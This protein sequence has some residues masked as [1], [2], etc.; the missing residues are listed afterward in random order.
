ML[1]LGLVV[2][3]VAIFLRKQIEL[4]EFWKHTISKILFVALFIAFLSTVFSAMPIVA[5]FGSFERGGGFI[6]LVFLFVWFLFN[7]TILDREFIDRCLKFSFAGASLLAFY[8]LL[9]RLGVEIFFSNFD[10]DIFVKRSFSFVGNPSF[11]GQFLA[12]EFFVGFY[13]FLNS[14]RRSA[15]VIFAILLI[16]IFAGILVSEA[17]ASL[18]ALFFGIFLLSISYLKKNKVHFKKIVFG[19]FATVLVLAVLLPNIS[20]TRF[21]FKDTAYQ[22]LQSRL[23]IW[24]STVEL[25]K[26]RPL[27]GYGFETFSI[28]FHDVVHKD[29]YKI[30]EDLNTSADRVHNEFLEL[31]YS[32]GIFAGVLYLF[33]IL[34]IFKRYFFEKDQLKLFLLVVV[35]VNAIQNQLSFIDINTAV[36][37]FFVLGALVA[38]ETSRHVVNFSRRVYELLLGIP[39][40]IVVFSSFI[41]NPFMSQIDYASSLAFRSISHDAAVLYLKSAIYYT[42]QYS[43]LWYELIFLDESSIPRALFYLDQIEHGSGNVIAWKANYLAEIEKKQSY[44][45]FEELIA[46]NPERPNWLRAYAD[47]TFKNGD[48]AKSLELYEKY[49]NVIPDFWKWDDVASRSA[50]QQK[51]HRVFFKYNSAVWDTVARYKKLQTL[52]AE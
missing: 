16:N 22:S 41:I 39:A 5:T 25:I 11:L 7:A 14:K 20:S 52:K 40:S 18:L 43:R 4:R 3:C 37:L 36:F 42:P 12:A 6:V 9:Q 17:R 49:L 32:A 38:L 45:L 23:S 46:R 28:Y 21:G 33:F 44:D 34:Y 29:F 26:K 2:F 13:L 15:Q 50:D 51:S 1:L 35:L 27:F 48:Y 8:A 47:A 24:S 10:I 31:T 30:E 19:F